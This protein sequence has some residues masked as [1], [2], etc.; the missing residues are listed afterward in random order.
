VGV[1]H[2]EFGPGDTLPTFDL[3]STSGG[4]ADRA[5][6]R[7]TFGLTQPVPGTLD[8]QVSEYLHQPLDRMSRMVYREIVTRG[9]AQGGSVPG[10]ETA[11]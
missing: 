4:I 9:R 5:Q 8:F 1:S 3:V 7:S 11:S 2:Y 6:A 10:S